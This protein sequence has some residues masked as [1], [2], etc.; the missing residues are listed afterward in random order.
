L[1]GL[2]P[3]GWYPVAV[4]TS[5]A[6]SELYVVSARGLGH[7]AAATAPF[8]NPDPVAL[9]ADGA[10][11]TAGTLQRI[12]IPDRA[13]LAADTRAARLSLRPWRPHDRTPLTEGPGGPIKHVIYITRENK[14]YDTDLGDLTPGPGTPLA[15]F[16][17]TVTPNLHELVRRY[18]DA[19][20]FYYPAF[21]STTG[22]MWEDAGGP[23]DVY[24]RE[25]T[26]NYLPASWSDQTNYPAAGLLVNQAL[27]AGLTVRTYNEETAQQ[28]RLLAS[29]YQAPTSVFPNYDLGY[30]DAGR[31][32]GWETEFN[33][34]AAHHCT[35]ALASTYGSGCELPSLE[36]VYLGEDHTT[37]VD[38]PGYPTVEA[39]V[40]DNDYAT[41]KIVE[42][43]SHSRYWGSTLIVIVE[44]DPQ[45]TGDHVSAYRGLVALA[46]PWIKRG[47]T[48]DVHYDWASA[49]GAIERVLGL[50]ALSD[51][52][53]T[54]RPLDD[55]FTNSPGYATFT[56]DTSGITAYPFTALPSSP[57][58]LPSLP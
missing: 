39:Q 12:P 9:G 45:G 58:P 36:Y 4:A 13:Q 26:E 54:V 14:L 48:T 50:A 49:V 22:H 52:V 44:D 16:G 7:S 15:V 55:M 21:R 40:A 37:V 53:A 6:N 46:S 43:V 5:A 20:Q 2:I 27:M 1:E 11:A 23:S 47:Y 35:G 41:A 57:V 51:Y 33:Q 32:H 19:T 8:V 31:E 18:A 10:Y 25:V 56:A 34:F 24:E 28:S 3:T 17:Q 30:P 29:Q 42:A 38:E